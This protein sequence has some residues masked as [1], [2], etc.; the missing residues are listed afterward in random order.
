MYMSYLYKSFRKFIQE[1]VN[2]PG[3]GLG[4]HVG[5]WGVNYGNTTKG[6]RNHFGEKGDG[7]A[8]ILRKSNTG[9]KI[10]K[11]L[12]NPVTNEMMHEDDVN[13]LYQEYK[14]KCMQNSETPNEFGTLTSDSI[15]YMLDYISNS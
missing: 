14:I 3:Y 9:I 11:V 13:K 10:P 6:V 7:D 1:N 12:Y 4:A 15:Q 2:S 8:N 5:N